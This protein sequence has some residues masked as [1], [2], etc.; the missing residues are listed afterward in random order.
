MAM[1]SFAPNFREAKFCGVPSRV[2]DKL[3]SV[4]GEKKKVAEHCSKVIEF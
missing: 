4:A 3:G 2:F 1:Y